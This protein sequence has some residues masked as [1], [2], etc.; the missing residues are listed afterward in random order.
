MFTKLIATMAFFATLPQAQAGGI[1][2]SGSPKASIVIEEFIDLQC[3][4]CSRGWQTMKQIQADYPDD[5]QLSY[6]NLPLKDHPNSKIAAQAVS[7]AAL[8]NLALVPQL[9]EE[10]LQ[11]QDRL[12]L[13]GE[14]YVNEAAE[15][16]GLDLKRLKVDASGPVVAQTISDDLDFAKKNSIEGAPTYRI[17]SVQMAGARSYQDFKKEIEKQ[18]TH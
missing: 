18:L 5:V 10:I 16:V 14:P 12:R 3:S 7:A 8:Q 4:Y 17:G 9:I 6:R 15:K 11:N 1:P 13:E 2:L